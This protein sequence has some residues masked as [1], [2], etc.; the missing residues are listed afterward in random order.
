MHEQAIVLYHG[1]V[2]ERLVCTEK[3]R[4]RYWKKIELLMVGG[5]LTLAVR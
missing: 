2:T 1:A 3:S 5:P 4:P